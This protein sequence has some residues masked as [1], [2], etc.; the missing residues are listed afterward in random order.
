M[1]III[2]GGRDFNNYKVLDRIATAIID[3]KEDE[4]VSGGARGADT[5][6]ATWAAEHNVPVK[7]FPAN[8]NRYG[9]S[10]GYIRNDEMGEYGDVLIAFWDKKS[11]GTLN[12]IKT[13]QLRRKP[14]FIYDYAGKEIAKWPSKIS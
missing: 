5:L 14:Y 2:A 8:W 3:P 12:M 4:I 1:R 10:A 7:T 11:K 6:G 9:K 13:M